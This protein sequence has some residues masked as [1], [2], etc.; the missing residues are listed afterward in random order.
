MT[1]RPV[2]GDPHQAF[3]ELGLGPGDG[4][5]VVGKGIYRR[6][7]EREVVRLTVIKYSALGVLGLDESGAARRAR[8]Y[9]VVS[10]EKRSG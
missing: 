10:Y 7:T 5:G 1:W 2:I 3:L 9:R 8:W 6:A 4:V